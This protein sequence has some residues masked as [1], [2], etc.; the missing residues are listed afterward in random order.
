MRFARMAVDFDF[1]GSLLPGHTNCISIASAYDF[2]PWLL[3]KYGIVGF[4]VIG[5]GRFAY[6]GTFDQ[7]PNLPLF[8]TIIGSLVLR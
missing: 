5:W 6:G 8:Y 4:F 7:L 1:L 2:A 3:P